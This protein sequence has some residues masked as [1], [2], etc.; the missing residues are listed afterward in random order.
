MARRRFHAYL[1]RGT[2]GSGTLLFTKAKAIRIPGS[3]LTLQEYGL[4]QGEVL[5]ESA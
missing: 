3:E 4:R 5:F 2:R 1:V